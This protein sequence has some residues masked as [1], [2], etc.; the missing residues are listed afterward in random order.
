MQGCDVVVIV[1]ERGFKQARKVLGRFGRISRTHYFNVLFLKADD[2]HQFL[3]FLRER[4]TEDPQFLSFLSRLV[5]VTKTFAFQSPEEFEE[6]AREAALSWISELA[7]KGFHVRMYRRGFKG[8]LSSPDEER[9]LD[10]IL[11]ESL[12]KA[13]T[14]GHITFVDPDAILVI[15]TIDAWAGLSLWKREDLERYPFIRLD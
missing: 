7:G 9:F 10:K 3:E 1:K 15:E 13:G 6:E 5:P 4:A 8:R 2:I 11:L 14:P 12:E